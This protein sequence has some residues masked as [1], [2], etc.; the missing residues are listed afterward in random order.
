[1][2]IEVANCVGASAPATSQ[3]H[4]LIGMRERAQLAGGSLHAGL[5]GELFLVR[6]SL[7]IGGNS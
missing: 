1:V 4:G 2:D 6:A 5:E 7:P 3:G